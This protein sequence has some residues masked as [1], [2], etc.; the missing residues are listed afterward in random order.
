MSGVEAGMRVTDR[1][2]SILVD[3]LWAHTALRA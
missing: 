1:I 3:R 2:R